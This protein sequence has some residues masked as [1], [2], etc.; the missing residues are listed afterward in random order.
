MAGAAYGSDALRE[1]I[2][3]AWANAVIKPSA[4]RKNKPFFA[5]VAHANHHHIK[6]TINKLKQF[7][8]IA[9]RYD[10][11]GRSCTSFVCPRVITLCLN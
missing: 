11:R 10:K 9:A 2:A 1:L 8:R 5:P 4:G 6:P 7:R 3:G